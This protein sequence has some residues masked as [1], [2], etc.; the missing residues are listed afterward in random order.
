MVS[1]MP[2]PAGA[3][4]DPPERREDVLTARIA[5]VMRHQLEKEYPS[6]GTRRDAHPKHT[7]LLEGVFTVT[8]TLPPELRVGVFAEPRSYQAWV[9]AS[10]ASAKP[11]SDAVRDVRGLAIKLLDVPGAKI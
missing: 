4:D 7:G 6:A 8:A 9:R 1:R 11:Q 2:S 5:T 10:N 3:T